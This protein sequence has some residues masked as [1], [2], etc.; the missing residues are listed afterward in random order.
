MSCL[1]LTQLTHP[2]L[3]DS[4]LHTD[5]NIE[6]GYWSTTIATNILLTILIVAHLMRVRHKSQSALGAQAQVPYL[7]ISA[8]LVEAAFL[9]TAFGLVF[10]IPYS[11]G[12]AVGVLFFSLIGQIQVCD[13]PLPQRFIF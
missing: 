3:T 6:L 13:R 1:L 9:Y 5:M 11:L 8:M 10:L 4:W 2:A 12:S 7:S